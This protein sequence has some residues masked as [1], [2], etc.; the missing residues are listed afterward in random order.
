MPVVNKINISQNFSYNKK[1]TRFYLC[2]P[3]FYFSIIFLSKRIFAIR[4][5]ACSN[6]LIT[7]TTQILIYI[8]SIEVGTSLIDKVKAIC[9]LT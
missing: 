4:Y 5:T 6:Y 3:S 7:S 2:Q 9:C 1:L 8:Y